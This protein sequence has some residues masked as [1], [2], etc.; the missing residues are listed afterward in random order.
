MCVKMV[1]QLKIIK[2][3]IETIGVK[4]VE[5]W[6]EIDDLRLSIVFS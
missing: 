4:A 1:I 2:T 5:G 6:F 3:I